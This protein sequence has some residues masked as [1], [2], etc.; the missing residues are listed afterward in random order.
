MSPA[1]SDLERRINT[2]KARPEGRG[3]A[4]HFFWLAVTFFLF[5]NLE[6]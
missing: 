2:A 6:R 4:L 3:P 1:L 5:S